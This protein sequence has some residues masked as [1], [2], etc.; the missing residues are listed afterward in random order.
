MAPASCGVHRLPQLRHTNKRTN[1]NE[2]LLNDNV[3]SSSKTHFELTNSDIPNDE[4]QTTRK[5]RQKVNGLVYFPIFWNAY[6]KKVGKKACEDYWLRHG[7]DKEIDILLENLKTRKELGY[8]QDK[9]FVC[10][11]IRYLKRK[12]WNDELIDRR[13]KSSADDDSDIQKY[14]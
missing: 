13:K 5:K 14:V 1:I 11:P 3:R 10:D 9:Q 6:D 2:S 7:L 8:Y 4:E 12:A